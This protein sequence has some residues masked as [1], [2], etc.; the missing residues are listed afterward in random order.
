MI[1]RVSKN[2]KGLTGEVTIPA[3]KSISHRAVMFSALANGKSI[4][5]NFSKGQDPHSTIR[6]FKELG[7]DITFQDETNLTIKSD[8][9]LNT[10][11][12]AL[13]CGNSGTTMRLISGILAGQNFNSVLLG[14]ASLSKRPMKRIIEPLTLMGANIESENNQAP[15]KIFGKKL[16]GISYTSPIASAQVKSCILL[17]GL[18]ADGVTKVTEPYLSRNHTE[19]MLE[20]MGAEINTDNNKV[21]VLPSK[22]TAKDIVNHYKEGD[23]D[24]VDRVL[25]DLKNNPTSRRILTNIYIS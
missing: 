11:Q 5:R 19:L 16:H 14:D 22:L 7:T 21:T 1:K 13:D 15:L 2:K 23:F 3:D 9:K 25:F 6:I 8:G 4:I 10:P 17:A 24:Q 18:N 12:N 20:Y